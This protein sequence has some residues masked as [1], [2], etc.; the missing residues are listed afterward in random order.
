MTFSDFVNF[1]LTSPHSGSAKGDVHFMPFQNL[2][3]PC[4][5]KYDY[6]G[7]FDSFERDS[8]VLMDHLGVTQE[9]L[10][11]SYYNNTTAAKKENYFDQL[12]DAQKRGVFE[13]LRNE[14]DLYYRIF[15]DERGI[16]KNMLNITDDIN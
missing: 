1:F 6:Y 8:K 14:L 10:R 4:V 9:Y 13:Y 12:S 16:H 5:A 2:C 11:P 3:N 7:N 15:P